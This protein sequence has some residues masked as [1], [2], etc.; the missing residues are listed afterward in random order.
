MAK[1]KV[2]PKEVVEEKPP[3][4]EAKPRTSPSNNLVVDL[5]SGVTERTF[6]ESSYWPDSQVKPYNPDDLVRKTN[7]YSI[8]EEMM[9]DDQVDVCLQIKKD[10]VVGSGWM[11]SP[12]GNED[13][14]EEIVADLKV[15]LGEDPEVHIDELIEEILSAYGYGFSLS[16]KLFKFRDDNTLTLRNIK[17]RHPSSWLIWTDEHG[18]VEKYE[19]HGPKGDIVVEPK[20]L[21]HYVNKR[22][23]GNPY[24][25]SDLR[26][27]YNAYFIKRQVIKWYAIFLEKHASPTVVGRYDKNAPKAAVD[28]IY[29]ALKS[30][31][32]STA[33]VIPKDIELEFLE[34]K[35][36]GE[37]YEKALNICNMFIGRAMMIPDL[38]GF[39]GSETGGG[40]Y[41]LGKDQ[42]SILFKHIMRRRTTIERIINKEIVFPIVVHNHGFQ[43]SY[44]KFKFHPINDEQTVELAKLWLECVKGKTYKASDEEINH[45]RGIVKFPEGDVERDAPLPVGGFGP[46]GKPAPGQEPPPE[47]GK[48]PK[49]DESEDTDG[50][51]AAGKKAPEEKGKGKEFTLKIYKQLPGDYDKK[52]DYAAIETSMERFKSRVMD[53]SLPIVRRTFEDLYEQIKTKKILQTQ[54]AEKLEDLKLRYLPELRRTLKGSL[55]EGYRE[56]RATG[57][58]EILKGT[59]RTPLPDEKFLEFLDAETF[60]YVGDWAYRVSQKTRVQ[61]LAA[62]RDGKPLSAVIDLLDEEGLSDSLVSLERYARTKFTDVMNRGRLAAFNDSGVVAAYQYSAILDDRSTEIC[63]GLHGKIFKNGS[64]PVPPMHFNCRSL[65]VPI[66]KYEAFEADDEV[67]GKPISDFIEENKGDGFSTR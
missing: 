47:G 52:V 41:S 66:T 51:E 20:S 23:F 36:A 22:A 45:F 21:I 59:F 65:L 53:E 42:I 30:L 16:E 17:T 55:R 12:E 25:R 62:I 67:A 61:L 18:N 14:N 3:Q 58:R 56:G 13:S 34:S 32:K 63:A 40:S 9:D 57:Q 26:T 54:N 48:P 35:S 49:G 37:A 29:R 24:G 10:L 38:L 1:Q 4:P 43:E 7:D 60:Q 2:A 50:E 5:Y 46:D 8:Y 6:E 31:Q 28:E 27:A 11:I 44:P 19:Q 33:M 39:Q 64:E 15:A